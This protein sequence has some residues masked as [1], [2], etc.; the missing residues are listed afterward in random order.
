MKSVLVTGC[1]GGIGK[2]LVV[3]F[4][5][6][7]WRVV[8]VD[9]ATMPSA[10][11]GFTPIEADISALVGD[12]KALEEFIEQVRGATKHAPL[13]GIVN[14]AAV[15]RLGSLATLDAQAISESFNVNAIAPLLLVK[16][17]LADLEEGGVVINIGSVHAQATKPGFAAYAAS[18]AA[19]H[20]VTRALAVDLGPSIR[21]FT[22]APAAV[23]TDM[24][25]AGFEGNDAA[26]ASL[27]DVHP[28]QRIASPEEIAGLVVL[29]T[30]PEP[31]FISGATIYA[32][33]G[34]LSA[35]H[36]PE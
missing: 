28:L 27:E 34:V 7:G 10:D 30:K 31:G 17:F 14:N 12:T 23:A 2:A 6:D 19:L 32:G 16:S 1:A 24:L 22:I 18:K 5:R 26:F 25:K 4:R 33:G 15:Q 8:G 20:G 29:M 36:A 13:K 9:C 21:T 3:A 11:D 35:L